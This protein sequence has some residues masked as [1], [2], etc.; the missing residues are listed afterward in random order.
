MSIAIKKRIIFIIVAFI[1]LSAF[2]LKDLKRDLKKAKENVNKVKA[3]TGKFTEKDEVEMGGVIISSLLG[4]APLV[5]DAT[6]QRY[7]NNVG[8]LIAQHSQRPHLPWTFGVIDNENI[9][10]FAAPGG[11]I[12]VTKGLMQYMQ[13][14]A[15]LAA[16]LAHEIIH[17]EHKHHLNILKKNSQLNIAAEWGVKQLDN[18]KKEKRVTKLVNAGT[19]MYARGLDKNAEYEADLKSV[20]LVLKAGYDPF[21]MLDILTTLESLHTAS[22]K[23]ALL[24][25]THPS[26]SSRIDSLDRGIDAMIPSD[27]RGQRV[28]QRFLQI[29]QRLD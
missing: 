3:V 12:L 4:A 13:N 26:F 22:T 10:A 7:I 14:E 24:T 27:Y 18:K 20:K 28:E 25:K 11:Y 16:V 15:E 2:N 17:V 9:N 23:L 19:T 8:Y 6:V 21:A 5:N 1:C 29:K